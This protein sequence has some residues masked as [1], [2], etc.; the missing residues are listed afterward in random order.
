MRDIGRNDPGFD[1]Y[2]ADQVTLVDTGFNGRIQGSINEIQNDYLV[3]LKM[4]N[5]WSPLLAGGTGAE[6]DG[7]FVNARVPLTHS[8][9]WD[10]YFETLDDDPVV[11]PIPGATYGVVGRFSDV[12]LGDLSVEMVSGAAT[13][14]DASDD[15]FR[16]VSG[17]QAALAFEATDLVFAAITDR[18]E[19][20]ARRT[21][22]FA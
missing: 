20:L 17:R 4:D 10:W 15:F 1:A 16:P 9:I 21:N 13:P 11:R 14:V 12:N 18:D 5:Y 6:Y 2:Q 7:P 3:P 22:R 8:G 19:L